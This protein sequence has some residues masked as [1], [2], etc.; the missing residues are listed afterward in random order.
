M[1]NAETMRAAL[2][3][4]LSEVKEVLK[5]AASSCSNAW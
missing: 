1:E 2:D 3:C 4:A 5:V